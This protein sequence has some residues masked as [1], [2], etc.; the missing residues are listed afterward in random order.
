MFSINKTWICIYIKH[1]YP[2]L[3]YTEPSYIYTSEAIKRFRLVLHWYGT[4][5]FVIIKGPWPLQWWA[6]TNSLYYTYPSYRY[7][8]CK[9]TCFSTNCCKKVVDN[10]GASALLSPISYNM[11]VKLLGHAIPGPHVMLGPGI[12]VPSNLK[13]C[14]ILMKAWRRKQPL[15]PSR[16]FM[17]MNYLCN[18]NND[19]AQGHHYW[20]YINTYSYRK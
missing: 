5:C 20:H 11:F 16:S 7:R 15:S 10:K 1:A 6:K 12:H 14:F 8:S 18:V 17:R 3:V 13:T 4:V 9:H 19:G 2:R